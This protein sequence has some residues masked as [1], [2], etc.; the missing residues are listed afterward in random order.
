LETVQKEGGEET[1]VPE[2]GSTFKNWSSLW[3][4]HKC[5]FPCFL[6]FCYSEL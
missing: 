2:F 3:R 4:S 5:N 1:T 6:W